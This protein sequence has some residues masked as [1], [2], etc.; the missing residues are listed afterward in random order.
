LGETVG[1]GSYGPWTIN[2][3]QTLTISVTGLTA[4]TQ[5]QAV[6]HADTEAN[7][8]PAPITQVVIASVDVPEPLEVT[9]TGAG[10]ELTTVPNLSTGVIA[11]QVPMTGSA[12]RLPLAIPSA[13]GVLIAAGHTN[14][15]TIEIGPAGVGAATGFVLSAGAMTPVLA[16]ANANELYAY[17]F[18]GDYISYL[19]I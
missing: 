17:G 9:G 2:A 5:Y 14:T 12:V 7:T 6:W 18:S 4:H 10:G 1:N 16:I 11:G 8:Y 3:Q 19:V 15:G 13:Q